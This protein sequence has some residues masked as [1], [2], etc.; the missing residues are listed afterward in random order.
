M[1][2]S[3]RLTAL[4]LGLGALSACTSS[5]IGGGQLM[6]ADARHEPVTFSWL[7]TD[8][9]M[10]G[11]MTAA[12]PGAVFEGRFFQITRQTRGEVLSPL[13]DHWHSGWYDWPYWNSPFPPAYPTAQ[14]IT[15]YSGKVVATL[16]SAD[17]QR[18]RCR[19][20]LAGPAQG[21]SGGGEGE[22]QLSDGRV[23]QAVFAGKER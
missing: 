17:Q 9:G 7:S 5:G 10:S 1:N 22:C 23:V 8:G 14:F 15:Y 16:A 4:L 21:M 12:L 2:P 6:G 18:M 19:F 11:T 13:W 3:R 20:H